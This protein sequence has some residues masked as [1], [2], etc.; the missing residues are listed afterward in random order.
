MVELNKFN[1]INLHIAIPFETFKRIA[2]VL[3]EQKVEDNIGWFNALILLPTRFNS[4]VNA[5]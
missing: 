5:Q 4:Q 3:F 1:E 2:D